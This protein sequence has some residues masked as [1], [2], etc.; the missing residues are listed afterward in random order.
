MPE[1]PETLNSKF[2]K[3]GAGDGSLAS[4]NKQIDMH[5]QAADNKSVLDKLVHFVYDKDAQSLDQLKQLKVQA[6]A[7]AVKGV[8]PT[9][10]SLRDEIR[11]AV[12]GDQQAVKAQNEVDF[13]AG[14]FIKAVPLFAGAKSRAMLAGSIVAYGLDSVHSKDTAGEASVNLAMG[15]LKGFALKKTFDYVGAKSFTLAPA[16][17]ASVTA[18]YMG[19]GLKGMALGA[20]SR[21]YE[22]GLT[23][24]TYL[25]EQ[26]KLTGESFTAGVGKTFSTAIDGKA[27]VMDA[28]LFMG[29]HGAFSGMSKVGMRL[30]EGSAVAES[31]AAS[32]V[33]KFVSESK[34]VSNAGMGATFGFSSGATNEFMRQKDSEDFAGGYDIARI[35]K[36]G[37]LQ[38]ITDG[39]AGGTGATALHLAARPNVGAQSET[40]SLTPGR[41]SRAFAG[42]EVPPPKVE[43]ATEPVRT[44]VAADAV[45]GAPK[46]TVASD[47]P[48]GAERVVEPAAEAKP[49][50][51]VKPAAEPVAEVKLSELDQSPDGFSNTRTHQ[52]SEAMKASFEQS[53]ALASKAVDYR[54][55]TDDVVAFFEHAAGDGR[56]ASVAMAKVAE[57]AKDLGNVPMEKLIKEAF[58]SSPESIA[59]LKEGVQLAE[60]AA[61]ANAS[62]LDVYKLLDYAYGQG[63]GAEVPLR[64]VT[65][66]AGDREVNQIVQEA[67]AGS[68]GLVR[69]INKVDRYTDPVPQEVKQSFAALMKMPVTSAAEHLQFRE[70]ARQWVNDNPGFTKLMEAYGNQTR[71]GVHAAVIDAVLHTDI[72]GK[73]PERSVTS[74]NLLEQLEAATGRR[75]LDGVEVAAE[76][77]Q[78]VE[79]TVRAQPEALAQAQKP[80]YSADQA[81]GDRQEAARL[82]AE[83]I[84]QNPDAAITHQGGR[85]VVSPETLIKEFQQAEGNTKLVKGTILSEFIGKMSDA[86][87]ADWLTHAYQPAN[88]PGM[89]PDVNNLALMHIGN[90]RVLN[91]AEVRDALSDPEHAKLDIPTIRKFLSAPEKTTPAPISDAE[92]GFIGHRLQLAYERLQTRNDMNPETAGKPVDNLAVLKEALPST[93][94][95]SLRERY[96]TLATDGSGH[97]EYPAGFDQNLANW[98]ETSRMV[99]MQSPKYRPPRPANNQLSDRLNVLD[100]AI[101]VQGTAANPQLVNRLLDLGT[102]NHFAVK[103]ILSKL[104]PTTSAPEHTE[105]LNL[106]VPRTG[107]L[108][109]VRGLLDAVQFGNKSNQNANK[110]REK[111][112]DAAYHDSA[113][114]TNEAFALS[115]V[116]RLIPQGEPGWQRAQQIVSDMISGKIRDPRPETPG[117]FGAPAGRGFERNGPGGARGNFRS[118]RGGDSPQERPR[119]EQP[120]RGAEVN[121]FK[122]KAADKPVDQVVDQTAEPVAKPVLEPVAEPIAEVV[123]PLQEAPVVLEPPTDASISQGLAD[124]LKQ[125]VPEDFTARLVEQGLVQPEGVVKPDAVVKPEG[126]AQPE[127]TAQPEIVTAPEV[128]RRNET[129]S[130][131]PVTHEPQVYVAEGVGNG[132]G[133]GRKPGKNKQNRRPVVEDDDWGDD[134]DGY[135]KGSK[136]D[137]QQRGGKRDF[138]RGFDE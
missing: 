119:V 73:F 89:H 26:G 24:S 23:S 29:A 106:V 28:G 48:I 49:V 127:V 56:S 8:L 3:A 123:K 96:S 18:K 4:L 83:R 58:R 111:G 72:L 98:L 33:G 71:V 55:T 137:K 27:M 77:T 34:L 115:I 120:L 47:A 101:D 69:V 41:N 85:A 36:R 79:A 21:I 130:E 19:V 102:Q 122:P 63:R 74:P 112:Q 104:D 107:S 93:Y 39:A 135:K 95:R 12:Q 9:G 84:A 67:Y 82:Q 109:D 116:N 129:S 35:L 30:F 105:L 113:R 76:T 25:N 92:L 14:S 88:Q 114:E 132:D 42:E 138:K 16:E 54:A 13:Y 11:Q 40:T 17:A 37:A 86:D 5:Q 43:A 15:G 46:E 10:S 31:L 99:E 118:N 45:P 1:N 136:R 91:R 97:Y 66:L 22:S 128:L 57:Q 126:A 87:F 20:S 131:P 52:V 38:A 100:L 70:S 80:E 53:V 124:L 62:P 117:G 50:V 121:N 59:T 94:L 32:K 61:K 103:N 44:D 7:Q 110:A 60:A 6:E 65:E 81:A 90:G 2:D 133:G 64:M 68:G 78:P 134:G 108:D 125:P 51:E 75:S